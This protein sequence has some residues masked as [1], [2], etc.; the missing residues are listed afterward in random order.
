M[1]IRKTNN[2]SL[3][4][5][6]INRIIEDLGLT[7]D[8][9]PRSIYEGRIASNFTLLTKEKGE[10]LVRSYPA[11][12]SQ[13][14]IS[15][16]IESLLFFSNQKVP[17]PNILLFQDGEILKC[18]KN[19][20]VFA[21]QMIDGKSPCQADLS[22]DLSKQT[23]E[24][25]GR[26]F[27]AS[28]QYISKDKIAVNDQKFIQNLFFKFKKKY[29]FLLKYLPIQEMDKLLKNKDLENWLDKSKK[30]LVHGDY[31]FENILI[32]NNKIVGIIDFGDVYYGSIVTDLIIGS[33]EFSVDATETFRIEWMKTFLENLHSWLI[34]FELSA[35]RFVDLLRINCIRFM[36][37]TIPFD[38]A[39]GFPPENNRYLTRFVTLNRPELTTA[40]NEIFS[41]LGVT[42]L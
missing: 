7:Q 19:Q 14:Q 24:I 40:I 1:I 29:S 21:Y 15:L 41:E 33:I 32:K 9:S 39:D 23:A 16:E 25:L 37:Y 31:F 18:Y 6:Y 20:W 42:S 26:F 8:G 3:K 11:G 4:K 34:I 2:L 28:S 5:S 27:T 38:L 17:V 36:I 13:D 22:N 35:A 10:I 30:G 12:Y